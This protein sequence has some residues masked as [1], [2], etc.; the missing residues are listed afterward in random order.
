M[1]SIPRGS[2]KFISIVSKLQKRKEITNEPDNKHSKTIE[3]LHS[4]SLKIEEMESARN[5]LSMIFFYFQQ[6]VFAKHRVKHN[7]M[8]KIKL[9]LS[10]LSFSRNLPYAYKK[11]SVLLGQ[12][13]HSFIYYFINLQKPLDFISSVPGATH[14]LAKSKRSQK[15]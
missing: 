13:V 3:C 11:K 4:L 8:L 5:L 15:C 10:I 1:L 12:F 7:L 6:N 14:F 2:R 9:Y